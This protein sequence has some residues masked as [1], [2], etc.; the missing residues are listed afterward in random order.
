MAVPHHGNHGHGGKPQ[1]V[2][3]FPHG[4]RRLDGAHTAGAM[5]DGRARRG[6]HHDVLGRR[7]DGQLVAQAG[8][9]LDWRWLRD[10]ALS[11]AVEVA[12]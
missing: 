8:V 3:G 5:T 4:I 11:L 1:H 6:G 2:R 7:S 9:L 12:E 10:Q